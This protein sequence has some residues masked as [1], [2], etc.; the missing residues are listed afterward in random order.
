MTRSEQERTRI[1]RSWLAEGSTRLSPT[2]RD[3]VLLELPGITQDGAHVLWRLPKTAYVAGAAA[4]VLIVTVFAGSRLLPGTGTGGVVPTAA[5]SPTAEQAPT[6]EAIDRRYRNVGFIGLPPEGAV[7]SDPHRT[8]LVDSYLQARKAGGP[9]YQGMAF[10][11]AD[12][13][14][15]WNEYYEGVPPTR[16]TGWLEQRLT[17]EGIELARRL[18]VD[19]VDPSNQRLDTARLPGLLP[20]HAWA[21]MTV[22]PYVAS[23]YAACLWVNGGRGAEDPSLAQKLARLPE[24]AQS[25]L[26][27]RPQADAP[28]TDDL[29]GDPTHCPKVSTDVARQLDAL[30][31]TADELGR[32][33]G[34]L[35]LVFETPKGAGNWQ[36]QVIFEP[37]LPDG[38]ITSSV[39]G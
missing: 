21:E 28:L 9:P 38:T 17:A 7:P 2:V 11:Y 29:Y 12:G 30:L 10:L 37:V 14:L 33:Q 31:R 20:A 27:G 8:E 23:E 19:T 26:R 1:V 3:A 25:I 4:A 36:L 34:G 24:A 13:R 15:I 16:S 18:A 22:R 39:W 5:P 35:A 32:S 6:A